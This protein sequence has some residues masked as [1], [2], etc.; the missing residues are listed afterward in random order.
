MNKVKTNHT[1]KMRVHNATHVHG[2]IGTVVA[3]KGR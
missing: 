3:P 1:T 2:A